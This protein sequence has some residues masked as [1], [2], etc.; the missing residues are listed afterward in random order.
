MQSISQGFIFCSPSPIDPVSLPEVSMP[1]TAFPNPFY[2]ERSIRP[3][4][5]L[6]LNLTKNLPGIYHALRTIRQ[7]SYVRTLRSSN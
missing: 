3:I 4:N 1:D 7:V 6:L 5:C 2:Y